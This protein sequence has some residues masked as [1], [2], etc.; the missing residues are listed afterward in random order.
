MNFI[1]LSQHNTITNWNL[2]KQSVDGV[3]LRCGYRGYGTGKLAIDTKFKQYASACKSQNIPFGIYFFTQAI[4]DRE[5]IEEADYCVKLANEVGATIKYI[6]YDS[7][8]SGTADKSGRAD[9]LTKDVRTKCA[10]AFCNRVEQLGYKS[11]VYASES[12]FVSN[13][14]FGNQIRVLEQI[15]QLKQQGLTIIFTTHQPEQA[16][17]Y[18]DQVVLFHQGKIMAQGFPQDVMIIWHLSKTYH[19]DKH[20]IQRALPFLRE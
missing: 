8:M 10:L 15:V 4:N 1:D 11:G 5:A 9:K 3:I 2:L 16:F 13:L 7:V 14:D 12:W 17:Y 20:Q 6:Y 19:L 18:T